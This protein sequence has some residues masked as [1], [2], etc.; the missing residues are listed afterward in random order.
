[1]VR[2]FV[3]RDR[4]DLCQGAGSV[5][6]PPPG[7]IIFT[8][9][10]RAIHN[11]WHSSRD[12]GPAPWHNPGAAAE[13]ADTSVFCTRVHLQH[14]PD[15]WDG[16]GGDKPAEGPRVRIPCARQ[17]EHVTQ[18][19][20]FPRGAPARAASTGHRG[21]I[22]SVPRVLAATSSPRES[23]FRAEFPFREASLQPG[24]PPESI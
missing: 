4:F 13:A 21:W 19:T 12:H 3:N 9:E 5:F 15:M 14:H 6:Q 22:T 20:L 7:R 24:G 23:G 18:S 2:W 17:R 8:S 1:M 16:V 11:R 10:L